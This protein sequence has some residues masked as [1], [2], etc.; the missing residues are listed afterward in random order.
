MRCSLDQ[1]K[2]QKI[3][4]KK[5]ISFLLN[6]VCSGC[7]FSIYLPSRFIAYVMGIEWQ[8]QGKCVSSVAILLI[9]KG[10]R[11]RRKREKKYDFKMIKRKR[12]H[13]S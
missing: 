4:H 5:N 12:F 6:T 1:Q 11:E 2:R 7:I 10:S 9:L 8:R 13:F 3:V